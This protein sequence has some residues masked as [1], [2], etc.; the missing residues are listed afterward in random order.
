LVGAFITSTLG[1]RLAEINISDMMD[2]Y[3][4]KY[5]ITAIPVGKNFKKN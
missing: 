5:G 3:R 1:Y 2:R 4:S